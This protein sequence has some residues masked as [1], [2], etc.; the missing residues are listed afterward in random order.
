MLVMS[1]FAPFAGGFIGTASAAGTTDAEIVGV[2]DDGTQIV[3]MDG[4]GKELGT[5][6][7]PLSEPIQDYDVSDDR[8]VLFYHNS[9]DG[10]AEL[11]VYDFDMNQVMFDGSPDTTNSAY[12]PHIRDDGQYVLLDSSRDTAIYDVGDGSIVNRIATQRNSGAEASF[13][14]GDDVFITHPDEGGSNSYV[15]NAYDYS[16]N[17]VWSVD[18]G[19]NNEIGGPQSI[20]LQEGDTRSEDV[21]YVE[22]GGDV[23]AYDAT[24]SAKQWEVL[25]DSTAA[26]T[27]PRYQDGADVVTAIETS[28]DEIYY[29]DPETGSTLKTTS[30]TYTANPG[31]KVSADGHA[32]LTSNNVV[33]NAHDFTEYYEISASV[34]TSTLTPIPSWEFGDVT[35][36]TV[37]NQNG[38]PVPGATVEVWAVDNSTVSGPTYDDRIAELNEIAADPLPDAFEQQGADFDVAEAYSNQSKVYPLVHHESAYTEA[39]STYLVSGTEIDDPVV[40]A[41]PGTIYQISLWDPEKKSEAAGVTNPSP[42]IDGQLPGATTSG[43]VTVEK[44]SPT[45]E[46]T[47]S[48]TVE[49]TERFTSNTTVLDRE[50]KTHETAEFAFEKD[51]VYRIST[52]GN[53][54]GYYVIAG[55][56][57]AAAA[58]I[59][60]SAKD[61]A[62]ALTSRSE[63]IQQR[64]ADNE[65]VRTTVQT[66]SNGEFEVAIPQRYDAVKMQA[67]SDSGKILSE[68]DPLNMTVDDLFAAYQTADTDA[69]IYLPGD[70]ETVDPPE[71]GVT[72]EVVEVTSPTDLQNQTGKLKELVDLFDAENYGELRDM[73]RDASERVPDAELAERYDAVMGLIEGTPLESQFVELAEERGVDTSI[74][75]EHD[76]ATK[77]AQIAVAQ[78]VLATAETQNEPPD[79]DDESVTNN[80]DGTVTVDIPTD[81]DL[82]EK[83]VEVIVSGDNGTSTVASD[84]N[85]TENDNPVRDD[86]I[87]VELGFNESDLTKTIE[88][89]TVDEEDGSVN[90]ESK[91]VSNPSNDGEIPRVESVTVNTLRP[92]AGD[93]VTISVNGEDSLK[94]VKSATVYGP[95]GSVVT[96]NV[97][98]AGEVVFTPSSP[99]QHTADVVLESTSNDTVTEQVRVKAVEE[100]KPAPPTVSMDDGPSGEYAVASDGVDSAKVSTSGNGEEVDV[101]A[102]FENGDVPSETVHVQ[103]LGQEYAAQDFTVRVAD[104]TGATVTDAVKVAVHTRDV[105]DDAHVYVNGEAV[106]VGETTAGGAVERAG[107]GLVIKGVAEGGSMDVSVDNNPGVLDRISWFIETRLPSIPVTVFPGSF[108]AFVGLVTVGARRRCERALTGGEADRGD[109]A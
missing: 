105:A 64:R 106:P 92:A 93:Q 83:S 76:R 18:T 79:K 3:F 36:G 7:N 12:H 8:I 80:D 16:G 14:A 84:E 48:V 11:G 31:P 75:R 27:T 104:E 49:T 26:F 60:Q 44:I 88:V 70:V 41:E 108:A 67:Y 23:A 86:T 2:S 62:G 63:T 54:V 91:R 97:N 74:D 99:G 22:S 87:E 43:N 29:L 17:K 77:E 21:L 90:R 52:P 37:K 56:P 32:F 72:L 102:R 78:E 65:F 101:T 59:R 103:G 1:I 19:T 13:F 61:D 42:P 57:A 95:D 33:V 9:T 20:G 24:D 47:D 30:G 53:D 96:S 58:S 46:V 98:T 51:G 68:T 28:D 5:A 45:G 6:A 81:G 66:D 94:S 85:V 50:L 35:T 4:D 39:K 71:S 82:D 89:V 25:V 38:D 34:S 40:Q 109:G 73:F 10:T 55:D 15:T 69:S 107:G 100:R